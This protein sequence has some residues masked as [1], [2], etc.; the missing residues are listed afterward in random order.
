MLI[1]QVQE[2]SFQEELISLHL[3][4]ERVI[5]ILL[6]HKPS[7]FLIFFN[8]II[9]VCSHLLH[10]C[11]RTEETEIGAMSVYFVADTLEGN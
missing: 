2:E 8:Y 5:L 9:M 1:E 11:I 4:V 6:Q 10:I 7:L 3:V